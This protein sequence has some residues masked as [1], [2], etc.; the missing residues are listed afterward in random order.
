MVLSCLQ[1]ET[2]WKPFGIPGYT[3]FLGKMS[4]DTVKSLPSR[5]WSCATLADGVAAAAKIAGLS[6]DD[7]LSQDPAKAGCIVIV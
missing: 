4:F 2:A 1:C 5:A 6:L 3:F 7:A